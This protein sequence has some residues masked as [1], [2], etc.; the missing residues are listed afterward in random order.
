M[1][2]RQIQTHWVS[3]DAKKLGTGPKGQIPT[4]LQ[5]FQDFRCGQGKIHP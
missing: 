2:M 4:E 3:A 5:S 1:Q